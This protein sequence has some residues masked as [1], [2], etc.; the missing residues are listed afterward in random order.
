M[1]N[2]K[3]KSHKEIIWDDY[4][5]GLKKLVSTKGRAS[6]LMAIGFVLTMIFGIYLANTISLFVDKWLG[7]LGL[8]GSS[9]VA[10]FGL[11]IAYHLFRSGW[12]GWKGD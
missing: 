10:L 4:G 11:I 6:A 5:K 7:D 1:N 2:E 9:I 12:E 8:L 3:L